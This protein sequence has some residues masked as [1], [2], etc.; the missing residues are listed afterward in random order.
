MMGL[1]ILLVDDEQD[2]QV[3][4]SRFMTKLGHRVECASEAAEALAKFHAA[5]FDVVIS[6]I[7]MPGM[8]GL[9]LLRRLKQVQ[10][11]PVDVIV[12]TGHGDM[13]N[14][15]SALKFGAFDYLR[16]PIDV[17]ELA[18]TLERIAELKRLRHN[19]RALKREFKQRV[20]EKT[21]AIRGEAERLRQAYLQEVGLGELRIFSG[22]MRAVMDLAQKYAEDATLPVLITGESGTGKELIAR[23]VHYSQALDPLRPFVA[24]NCGAISPQLFE[25]EFFGHEAGAYTGATT[26]GQRGKLEAAHGGTIFLDEIGE[27]PAGLQVKLLRVLEDSRF[28]RVGGTRE[29]AIE[30]RV[31]S[32][33]NKDLAAETE[34]GRFRTDLYYRVNAGAIR[35]PALR[36]RSDEILPFALHF[37]IRAAKRRGREFGGFTAGAQRMLAEHP[38]PG[39]VRQLK[40]LMER[41]ALLGPLEGV[42]AADLR[43]LDQDGLAA[44]CPAPAGAPAGPD[45]PQ[46]GLDLEAM[47]RDILTKTLARFQGNQTK[48][49]QYLG[50]SRRV[51]QGRLKKLSD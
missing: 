18:V 11:S 41:L 31:I 28:Y 21:Q 5:Q 2:V 32:A 17:R 40:N 25:G 44:A 51:L 33:T 10:A 35:I 9:E 19:Y 16:K 8:D 23:Y 7:R 26:S 3:S 45:L 30:A 27:M 24:V 42:T 1:A 48:A 49:A 38:W 4:L 50:L 14:A 12:I 20:E 22:A 36:E 29:V 47:N 46:G 37:A 13:D 34:A 43:R 15:I 6:D 39:N